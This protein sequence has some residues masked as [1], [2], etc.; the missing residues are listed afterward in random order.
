M[1]LGSGSFEVQ[2][3]RRMERLIAGRVIYSE[4][5]RGPSS[6]EGIGFFLFGLDKGALLNLAVPGECW[7][8]RNLEMARKVFL[9]SD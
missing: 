2:A 1:G 5:T 4:R 3:D 6:R 7:G 8:R 9:A